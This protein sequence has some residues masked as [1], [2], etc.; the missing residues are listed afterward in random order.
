MIPMT[1]TFLIF[2]K[3]DGDGEVGWCTKFNGDC[4]DVKNC[5]HRGENYAK[6]EA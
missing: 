6:K 1:C 4:D 2:V 3:R 5:P